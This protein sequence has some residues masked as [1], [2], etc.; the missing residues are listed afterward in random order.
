M[1]EDDPRTFPPIDGDERSTLAG[2]LQHHR[3]TLEWKCRGL[4]RAALAATTAS[5][6]MTLGGLLKHLAFVEDHWSVYWV[7]GRERSAPWATV[8]WAADPDWDWNSAVDDEPEDLLAMWKA[9]ARLAQ[10]TLDA[11]IDESGLDGV[12]S[13]R[14]REGEAVS[15]RW[16]YVHLIEE[17]ARHNGHADLLRE[18]IDGETGE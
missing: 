18:A 14:N 13:R 6:T 12:A 4:D 16:V 2:F 9:S 11:A 7:A 5:S 1:S 17:Y 3:D 8:D 15:L 10:H